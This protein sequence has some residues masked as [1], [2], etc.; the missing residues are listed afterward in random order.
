MPYPFQVGERYLPRE[1]SYAL[2]YT[3]LQMKSDMDRDSD[4]VVRRWNLGFTSVAVRIV[5]WKLDSENLSRH[6]GSLHTAFH[7]GEGNLSRG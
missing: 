2:P 4:L 1:A 7:L 5:K 6:R 3:I